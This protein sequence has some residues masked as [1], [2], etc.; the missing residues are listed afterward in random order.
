M[1]GLDRVVAARRHAALAVPGVVGGSQ[2][3]EI[4]GNAVRFAQLR[5][6]C[7]LGGELGEGGQQRLVGLGIEGR[8]IE[9]GVAADAVGGRIA[10]DVAGAHVRV[11]HVVHRVVVGVLREQVQVDVDLGVHRHA[12][13]GVACGVHTHGVDEVVE[14][15]DRAGALGHAHG[16]AVLDEVDELAD[17]DLE[18]LARLVAERGTHGHHAADVAVVVGAQQVD[19]NVRATLTLIE[20][21]GDVA[22][23]VR[24]LTVRLDE[25]A[26]L[27]VAVGGGAQPHRAAL[28]EDL[29]TLTQALDRRGDRAGGV[30]G[31]LVEEDVEVG[32]EGVQA[33]LDLREHEL[34][35]AS[36]ED[37]DGLFLGQGDRVGLTGGAR[38]GANLVG[39]VGDVLAAVAVLGDLAAH[40]AGVEG[41]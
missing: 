12:H 6:L 13:E 26:V 29:A 7:D 8:G 5:G 25:D 9:T 20:V 3:L 22:R 11:L 27:V 18:V 40:G 35:T 15:D 41:V 33:F 2:G 14:R 10:R 19:G 17:E 30:Q 39:D 34:D 31:V 32:A 36:A 1:A 23:E 21:V 38:V 28:V 4:A 24:G 37:L 16:L